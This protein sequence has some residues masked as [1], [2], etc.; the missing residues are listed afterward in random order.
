PVITSAPPPA[1]VAGV[2]Y[3][4][5]FITSGSPPSAFT[6]T[7]GTLPPGITLSGAALTGTPASPGIFPN[8]TVSAANGLAPNASQ[9]FAITIADT[10]QRYI[11]S[12]GLTGADT[13]ATAD[14]DF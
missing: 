3:T 14:P 9:T 1:G 8:L 5:T 7:A 13:A 11:G 4:H 2:A 6:I 10:L 12:F